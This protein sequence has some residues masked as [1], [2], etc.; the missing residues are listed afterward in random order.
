MPDV[1][2]FRFKKAELGV[3]C[4]SAFIVTEK[5][6]K[7]CR[8]LG[9]TRGDFSLIDLI[10]AILKKIGKSDVYISTWSAGIKDANNVKWIKENDM[11]DKLMLITD[12]SFATRQKKYALSITELFGIENIRTTEVHA[13]FV[14]IKNKNWSI[15][16]RSSMNL[17]ANKTCESFEIDDNKEIFDFYYK[18]VDHVK[19]NKVKGFDQ[20]SKAASI[21]LDLFCSD[22]AVEST[23]MDFWSNE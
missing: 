6:E 17:N 4:E 22:F 5:L 19:N 21:Q 1:A 3:F 23:N 16:I 9:L 14:L 18:F 8:I 12:H 15:T 11:I 2:S 7:N 20:S 13:K 10:Y